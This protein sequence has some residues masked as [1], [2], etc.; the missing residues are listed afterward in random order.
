MSNKTIVKKLI[1][2]RYVAE[3][4]AEAPIQEIDCTLLTALNDVCNALDLTQAEKRYV[5]GPAFDLLGEDEQQAVFVPMFQHLPL[6]AISE[7]GL[8]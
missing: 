3:R 4:E 6:R 2:L 5:L 7:L 8:N 1:T